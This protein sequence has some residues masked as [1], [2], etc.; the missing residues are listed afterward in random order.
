MLSTNQSARVNPRPL[1]MSACDD[2]S[3]M[4]I[5]KGFLTEFNSR[6]Q[7]HDTNTPRFSRPRRR[8]SGS[9]D[10]RTPS[11]LAGE[12]RE[13]GRVS[14]LDPSDKAV[15]RAQPPS[16][17]PSP[18]RGEGARSPFGQGCYCYFNGIG[19]GPGPYTVQEA[20]TRPGGMARW[21]G[22]RR[23]ISGAWITPSGDQ[24]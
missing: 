18:A 3:S 9:S 22:W 23:S 1:R 2:G 15:G 13:R 24:K 12:G 21:E 14:Q 7:F 10:S 16:P 19:P 4:E 8:S 5:C 17:Q 20:S 6:S 11:P